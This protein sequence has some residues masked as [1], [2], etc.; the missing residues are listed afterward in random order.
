MGK[1]S[2]LCIW[3]DLAFTVTASE[4]AVPVLEIGSEVTAGSSAKL[5]A[6]CLMAGKSRQNKN[7][8]KRSRKQQRKHYN[9]AIYIPQVS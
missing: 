4:V 8:L 1:K 6:P 5:L 2:S 9:A 7:Y 3:S